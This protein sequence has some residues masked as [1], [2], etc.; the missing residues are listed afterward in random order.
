MLPWQSRTSIPGCWTWNDASSE[1]RSR[2]AGRLCTVPIASL[3]RLSPFIGHAHPTVVDAL[4]DQ[5]GICT[6]AAPARSRR[7]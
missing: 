1:G 2:K 6:Y 7:P 3:P 4:R 5:V